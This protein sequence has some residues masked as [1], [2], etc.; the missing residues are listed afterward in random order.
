M[1]H[2]LRSVIVVGI[3]GGQS[4]ISF[5][6]APTGGAKPAATQPEAKPAQAAV[7]PGPDRADQRLSTVAGFTVDYPKKDWNLLVGVGSSVVVF[8]H[9]SREAAVSIERSRLQVPL[10]MKEVTD[11]TA[12][13]EIEEWQGR[14]PLAT[15]FSHQFVDF[16]E[17]RTI[18]IDFNQPGAQGAEHVRL[19]TLPRGNDKFRVIC[20]TT[21][22]TFDKYKET[23]HRMALSVFPT[24]SQ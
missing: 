10:S 5:A 18:I 1:K 4:L 12:T 14:R 23:L 3:I 24:T 15:G 21:Q 11:Q 22:P 17:A 13:N 6:Q 20:T 16:A 7:R 19:Y 8:F 2:T 9:K